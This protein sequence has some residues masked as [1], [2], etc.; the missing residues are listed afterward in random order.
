MNGLI[1]NRCDGPPCPRCGCQDCEVHNWPRD[2]SQ[3]WYASGRATCRHCGT[4][5]AF[6][7]AIN[8]QG[9]T[10]AGAL[11]DAAQA[12]APPLMAD[13]YQATAAPC[14]DFQ[15]PPPDSLRNKQDPTICPA[16]GHTAKAYATKGRTQ[17]RRCP[18]CGNRFKTMRE[19]G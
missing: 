16:C 18:E 5:F 1:I 17:Y 7:P 2:A 3:S 12:I 6:R 8:G 15:Q 11:E 13:A 14:V 19:A 9:P 10:E 4:F